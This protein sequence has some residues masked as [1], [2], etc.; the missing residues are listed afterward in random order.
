MRALYGAGNDGD[1]GLI[2]VLN[3]CNDTL[4]AY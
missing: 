2:R 4:S 3:G 1:G